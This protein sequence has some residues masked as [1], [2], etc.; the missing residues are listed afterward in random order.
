M[1][2][3]LRKTPAPAP[4]AEPQT[5]NHYRLSRKLGEGGM[6]VVYEAY[7]ER[8]DRSVAIK[9]LRSVSTDPIL[10]ERL[11]R[12]AR[13]AAGVSHPNVCQVYELGDYE[14]EL[15]IVMELLAGETL[16]Q[17]IGQGALQLS[18]S[19]QITLGVLSALDALHSRGIV[20]RDLKP[21]NIF[22]TPHG[23]KLLDFGVA[24]PRS[25]DELDPG[26]TAPGTIIGTPRYLAPELL[27]S[28]PATPAADLFA[29]GAILFE[30]LT[31][32]HAFGGATVLEVAHAIMHEQPPPLVG[33]QDV[34]AVDR[35]I[36]RAL[37]KRALDR[38]PDA[39]TMAQEIRQ[40][41]TLLDTGPAPRVRTMTRLIVLPFRVLRPDPEIDF[42][43][44]S[45]PEAIT[46]S[47][48]GLETLTVRS[49]AAGERYAGERPDLRAIASEAGVDVVLLGNL[50]RAGD[51][52]RLSTQLVEAPSGTVVSTR[53]A[54][55]PL[56]DIFQLQDELTRLVVD[57]LAIPL[58][59][60]E[61]SVLHHDVPRD[62]EAYE[63]Y[64]R[65]NHIS[66]GSA[67]P[68]RLTTARDLYTRCLEKDP[69]Y[70]PAW[71][72]LG[73]VH[74]V[75]SKYGYGDSNH[76]IQRAEEAFRRAL[77]INPDLPLA[78]NLYTYFEIEELA[79]AREAM[80]RLLRMVE[81]RAADADLYAGLVV[82]CRF[83]GLLD[84]SLAADQRARRIN[85]GVRT[86]VAYTHWMLGNYEQVMVTDLEEIQALRNG[87]LWMLGQRE[88]A[89]Q[90]V[91]RLEAYW[92]GGA[93]VWYL[94]AQ[95]HAF[96]G[97]RERCAA[98]LHRV[99][100]SGFHDPE[101][102]YFCLRNAAFVGEG[103]LALEMLTRV[104]DMGFHC[105]TPLV[106][107]PWLDPIR[108]APEFVRALRR[109]EE[110][111][112][113]AKQAYVSAG[114]ERLLG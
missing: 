110:E 11:S 73:R 31:G 29:M 80:L 15:Y 85:P 89:L 96:E 71:A 48:S 59:A 52:V 62:P 77:E 26:L 81:S 67:S 113:A 8:L 5:I 16:A 102:L 101:G 46:A 9:R 99:L 28:E 104:V 86:S 25:T 6:G 23:P 43:A 60:H 79:R 19:L 32:R 57:A 108:T 44:V 13:V 36:Q 51:Q 94:R 63:L 50:L 54:Q 74:R 53:T 91:K 100:E 30:M 68:G 92:P 70:A 93:D 27:G 35:V 45:L 40:A 95:L 56:K 22:L 20:H 1:F 47:L 103:Q 49:S 33:G 87:A 7:D 76:D 34:V 65:A 98:A 37:A 3:W 12:E 90:G 106:R 88:E 83:C 55:A 41:L 10:R 38:H 69:E 42:L 97:D 24:R 114:G 107:D 21:S 39:G 64:L 2:R 109:A 18:E 105:P 112:G 14:G 17:R 72:R 66:E 111:H 82:A 75:M 84:A 78:H 58:T 61:E 4:G